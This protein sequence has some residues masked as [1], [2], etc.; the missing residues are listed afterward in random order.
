MVTVSTEQNAIDTVLCRRL[1]IR[2]P[3]VQGGMTLA[4]TGRLA[5][6]VSNCGG[7]G[8]VSSGRLSASEFERELDLALGATDKPLGVNLPIGRDDDWLRDIV[9]IS[10]RRSIKIVFIGGGNPRPWYAP[11]K[12]AGKLLGVV[13]AS[14]QQAVKAEAAGA[15]V[16]VAES[17]EAGGRTSRHGI[18]GVTLIPA[19]AERISVPLIAAGGFV[20]GRGLAAALCL[21]A[22]GVQMGTRFM[23][24]EEGPLHVRALE[25]LI[26]S[27]VTDTLIIGAYH[28]LG[29]R[30]LRGPASED[31]QRQ[32]KT[33]TLSEMRELLSGERSRQGLLEGD[34]EKGMIA[35]GEG[36]GL[37]S[38][39]LPVAEIIQRTMRQAEICLSRSGRRAG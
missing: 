9:R 21:G 3:I 19:T 10:T 31:V 5:A 26:R 20:D 36:A 24:A 30:V 18:S 34:V 23:L 38:E 29:R 27:E 17:I 16:I 6:A 32:E 11:I 13:V 8:I 35:C 14:P 7:L 15:D 37:I 4:G 12:D 28:N 39:V 33:A 22:H 25:A 1:E 2:Y